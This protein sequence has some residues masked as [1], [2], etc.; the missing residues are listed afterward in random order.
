[1]SETIREFI[2]RRAERR[3]YTFAQMRD[4]DRHGPIALARQHVMREAWDAG[5]S[6]SA[7]GRELERHHSTVWHGVRV[8]DATRGD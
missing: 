8:S 1:M 5:F 4:K 2:S 7:I 6:L 3:G